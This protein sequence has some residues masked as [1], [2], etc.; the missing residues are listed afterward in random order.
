[1]QINW[2]PAVDANLR[3]NRRIT[4]LFCGKFLSSTYLQG[5]GPETLQKV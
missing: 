3:V 1:M 4:L 2:F 5:F